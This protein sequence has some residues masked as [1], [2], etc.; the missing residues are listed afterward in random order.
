MSITTE[1]GMKIWVWA[2]VW[3]TASFT[4]GKCLGV[5]WLDRVSGECG[6]FEEAAMLY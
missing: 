1:A 4:S 5:G 6:H 2:F 3:L